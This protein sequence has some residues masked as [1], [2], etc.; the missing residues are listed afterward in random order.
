M[1]ILF[2]YTSSFIYRIFINVSQEILNERTILF[3]EYKSLINNFTVQ[4][5]C[6]VIFQ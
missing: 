3:M 2:L 4:T 6:R 1:S 5:M